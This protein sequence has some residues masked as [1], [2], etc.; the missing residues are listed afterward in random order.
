MG[1]KTIG[2]FSP[3]A[4]AE[5]PY[6]ARPRSWRYR[7]LSKFKSFFDVSVLLVIMNFGHNIVKVTL[8]M[9]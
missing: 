5:A 4:S 3:N 2:W 9:L 6:I 8:K 1:D 7:R